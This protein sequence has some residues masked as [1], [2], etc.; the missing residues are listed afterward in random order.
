VPLAPLSLTMFS[1]EEL[2][3]RLINVVL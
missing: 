3:K 1:P 2:V